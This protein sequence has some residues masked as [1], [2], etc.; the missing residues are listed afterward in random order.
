MK[1]LFCLTGWMNNYKGVTEDDP[2]IGGGSWI[3]DNGYGGEVYNFST[4]YRSVDLCHF[5]IDDEYIDEYGEIDIHCGYVMTHGQIHIEKLGATQ[6]DDY[7]NGILVV[8]LATHPIEGGIRIVGWYKDA[9]VYRWP[10]NVELIGSDEEEII[11]DT[12]EYLTY[13][14][15]ALADK[16]MLLAPEH[17][18]FRI[19]RA[20]SSGS[21]IGQSQV[22]YGQGQK[23]LELV[24]KVKAYIADND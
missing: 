19:P 6:N 3:K 13:S 23:N 21:G 9:T 24:E 2:I 12:E 8:W 14:I 18:T 10:L 15:E 17:R 7:V 22:W 16:C 11:D 20:T 1:I 5:E 4:Y